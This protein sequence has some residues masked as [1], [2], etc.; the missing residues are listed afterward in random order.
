M[1]KRKTHIELKRGDAIKLVVKSNE[2]VEARYMFNVW[3]SRFFHTLISMIG[4]DDED[5][6]VYRIWL[7]EIKDNFNINS[8]KSYIGWMDDEYR[9]GREYNLFEFVDYLEGGQNGNNLHQQEYVDVKIQEKM[10]PFLLYVKKKYDPLTT[11]YTSYDM[12]NT[13]KL[14]PYAIRIYELLKQFEYKGFRTIGVQDLKDMFLIT[15]EYPRFSTFNQSVIIPSITAINKY[16][17]LYVNPKR[18]EKIK[19]GRKV[20]SLRFSIESKTKQQ[21]AVLRGESDLAT[22]SINIDEKKTKND[23]EIVVKSEAEQLFDRFENV[24][25]KSFGVTPSSFIKML[26]TGNYNS[27]DIEQAISITQK[28]NNKQE[29]TKNVAGF[30][31]Q[32]LKEGYIDVRKQSKKIPQQKNQYQ[33]QLEKQYKMKLAS[34]KSKKYKAEEILVNQ[35][36]GNIEVVE[37][38]KVEL[39]SNHFAKYDRSMTFTENLLAKHSFKIIVHN[40]VLKLESFKFEGIQTKFEEEVSLLEKAYKK[41]LLDLR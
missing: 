27:I 1:A 28:A 12:R 16:T 15:D 40:T 22:L 8:N 32:A 30:F 31:L 14:K 3:E 10:R 11:R 39:E 29:I 17:D 13:Q 35:L 34:I 6:K 20:E 25:I 38:V 7:K 9:R 21:V 24:V 18:I 26:K 33:Q 5:E 2:L 41:A 23:A 19:R 4:K 37:K 36:L